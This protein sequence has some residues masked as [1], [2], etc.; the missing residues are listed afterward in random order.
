MSSTTLTHLKFAQGERY[1]ML[2]DANGLPDFWVTLYVTVKLRT[3]LKQ[4]TIENSIR[5][6]IHLKLWEQL[7][8]R[9]LLSEISQGKFLSDQDIQSIHDH[10]LNNARSLRNWSGTKSQKNV[11][12][13]STSHPFSVRQLETVSK[14]HAAN[15]LVE[16]ANF[17]EFAANSMLRQRPDFI[18]IKPKIEKMKSQ[19]LAQ[20]PKGLD[21]KGMSYDPDS[22]APSPEV[23]E[24][25][26]R[27]VDLTSPDNPYKSLPVRTRNSLIFEVLHETGIRAGELLALRVGDVD[28]NAGKIKIVRRHD[29]PLDPR[30]KQPVPKRLERDLD[31]SMDLARRL[32]AYVMDFRSQVINAK[33]PPF[34]F[35]NHKQGAFQGQPISDSSFRNRILGPAIAVA[36]EN[37]A[38]VTRH[39]FRHNHNYRLS[40]KIDERN[41]LSKVDSSVRPIGEKHEIQVRKQQ[42]GW[43]S[44]G[45]AATYNVRHTR[46]VVKDLMLEDG[47]ELAQHI[48]KSST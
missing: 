43:T 29:D 38:E 46:E 34:L 24:A 10:C 26:M 9:N 2:L 13:L 8:E 23:F 11:V 30:P 5:H 40:K 14:T 18:S 21:T 12:N 37:F 15:R 27:V 42:Y 22:K 6:I 19:I 41:A 4:N 25:I 1:P 39:G 45:T 44:D 47:R 17:L 48:T 35:V 3:D 31:I 32:R 20:K 16:I 36:P 33:S 28:Y 7:N